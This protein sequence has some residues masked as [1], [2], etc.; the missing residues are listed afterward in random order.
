MENSLISKKATK[1]P[2]R[3][4]NTEARDAVFAALIFISVSL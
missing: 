2:P 1:N 4:L 3:I